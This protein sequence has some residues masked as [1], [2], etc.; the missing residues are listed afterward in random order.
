MI[1]DLKI[2]QLV[3][4]NVVLPKDVE[5]KINDAYSIIR[6]DGMKMKSIKSYRYRKIAVIVLVAIA[7]V[8]I[9]ALPAV[10][11]GI[12]NILNMWS[13]E[14]DSGIYNALN[15]GVYQNI[16]GIYAS[17]NDTKIEVVTVFADTNRIGITIKIDFEENKNVILDV[18]DGGGFDYNISDQKGKLLYSFARLEDSSLEP[19]N[20]E[21]IHSSNKMY[22]WDG[23]LYCNILLSSTDSIFENISG[24]QFNGQLLS[25]NEKSGL[26]SSWKQYEGQWHLEIPIEQNKDQNN[27]SANNLEDVIKLNKA[28]STPFGFVID[29]TIINQGADNESLVS[30]IRIIDEE[31]NGFEPKQGFS[32]VN[33]EEGARLTGFIESSYYNNCEKLVL[34]CPDGNGDFYEVALSRND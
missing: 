2:K 12:S 33:T 18:G 5:N 3:N 7:L 19:F 15:Q 26:K 27:Y 9:S 30:G 8:S 21:I 24:I 28:L 1:D 4:R 32:L 13:E 22:K 23:E 10:R 20:T 31:G 11:A 34:Y 6:K 14:N 16:E 25:I 29:Y 17:S